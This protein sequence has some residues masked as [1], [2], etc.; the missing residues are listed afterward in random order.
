MEMVSG[1]G[2]VRPLVAAGVSGLIALRSWRKKSLSTSGAWAGVVVLTLSLMAGPRFGAV[3]LA[4][5]FSSSQLTK[6][7]SDVKKSIE[8]DFKDGGQRDWSQVLANGLVGTL[9]SVGVAVMTEWQDAC[10]DSKTAPLVTAMMAG[11]LGHYACCNGD[12]WSSEVGVL[13]KSQPRLITSFKTVPRGTNGGVSVLGTAAAAAGGAFIGL[14]FVVVGLFS[15]P[16]EGHVWRMQLLALPLGTLCG[17]LGSVLDSFLGATV[18][19]SGNCV[20]RKKVVGKPGPTV[21]RISGHDFMSNTDVN[22]VSALVTA[23]AS[24]AASR[25]IF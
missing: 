2:V 5:F 17:L 4:F 13:S 19:F 8:E 21:Q 6:Y 12:T 15:A 7:K 24:A 3:I 25:Y 20:V 23:L 16:C 14:V 11:V 10:L 9:L 18:Q 22:F 1:L